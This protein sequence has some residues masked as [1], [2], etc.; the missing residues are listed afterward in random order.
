MRRW[1]GLFVVFAAVALVAIALA[2]RLSSIESRFQN[3]QP[4]MSRAEVVRLMGE[5]FSANHDDSHME[6]PLVLEWQ[7][8]AGEQFFVIIGSDGVVTSKVIDRN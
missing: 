2:P 4:G 7:S 1:L 3:I 6:R 5:P 8:N